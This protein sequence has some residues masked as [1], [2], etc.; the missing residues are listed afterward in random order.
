MVGELLECRVGH[1]EARLEGARE[2]DA[3]EP[4]VFRLRHGQRTQQHGVHDAE[5]GGVGRDA[6]GKHEERD[7]REAAAAAET[8]QRVGDILTSR[9]QH[10]GNSIG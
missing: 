2:H 10:A 3:Q 7:E 9:V 8:A 5:D 1:P 6:E 4:Q